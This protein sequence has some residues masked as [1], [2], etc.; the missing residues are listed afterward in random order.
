MR[1]VGSVPA[2]A[3]KQLSA[4]LQH[5]HIAVTSAVHVIAPYV[6][7]LRHI[8]MRPEWVA[9]INLKIK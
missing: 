5:Q 4:L 8:F 2:G 3:I 6:R 9:K 7:Q 1:V